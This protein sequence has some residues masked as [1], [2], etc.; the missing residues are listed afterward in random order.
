MVTAGVYLIARSAELYALVPDVQN[1]VAI[2]GALTALFAATIAV[3]QF[4]IK[5]VLAYSTISQLGFMVSAV[6]MGAIV[7]GMF[8][9]VTHAFFKALL[10]LSAGSVIQGVERGHHHVEHDPSLK[11]QA[12]SMGHDFDPQEMRNMGGLYDRTKLTFWVYLIGAIALAGIF[13]FAGFWSKDEILAE[14]TELNVWAF[15]L[16]SLAAVFTAFYVTRQVLMVFFGKP[17]SPAAAHASESPPLVTVPLVILAALSAL[18]GLLNLPEVH[19]LTQWLEHTNEHLHEG[20]FVLW[21]AILSSVLAVL[22]VIL[23]WAIYNPRRYEAFWSTLAAKRPDD[24]LRRWIGP[25]FTV[26]KN[27]YWVDELYWAVIVNPYIAL[28]RFLADAV[29]WRFWHDWFHD[30]VIVAGFNGL[31]RFLAMSFDL[32]VIDGAANGIA[33]LVKRAAASLRQSQ[34][35]YVRNYALTVFLGV[36]LIIAYL[37]LAN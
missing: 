1:I 11:S 7:A 2:T 34:T 18:G 17:R 19:T 35:G 36:V 30:K 16:L 24:P 26:L 4:D 28:S 15:R 13:P 27:K 37:I 12:E 14:G 25:V 3:A 23:G 20:H 6:G 21:V 8:H 22:A 10:F 5:R 31:S 33:D 9:L 32:G 29:D